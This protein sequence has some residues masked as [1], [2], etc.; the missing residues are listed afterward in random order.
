VAGRF[1][2]F[3]DENS[4]KGIG[5]ELIK[6]GWDVVRGVLT[7]PLG[8][9]DDVVLEK[10]VELNRVLLTR[11]VDLEIIALRWVQQ[12]HP[13]PGVI[14]WRQ[15]DRQEK[16]TIGEVVAAIEALALND[17]PFAYP[18]VYLRPRK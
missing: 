7:V 6:R 2:I 8:T 10:A 3:V 14:F 1:P 4:A 15:E 11:D 5:K 18:I 17:E 9:D 13:L 12:W 16:S